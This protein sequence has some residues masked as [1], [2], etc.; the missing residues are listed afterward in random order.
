VSP[1]SSDNSSDQPTARPRSHL[2]RR[3]GQLLPNP[4]DHPTQT[5]VDWFQEIDFA[6]HV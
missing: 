3:L 2:E 1:V 5:R 6:D 4:Q